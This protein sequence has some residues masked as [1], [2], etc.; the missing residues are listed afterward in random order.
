MVWGIGEKGIRGKGNW[1]TGNWGMRG[2]REGGNWGLGK[3]EN[4]N[5][6]MLYIIILS[7]NSGEFPRKRGKRKKERYKCQEL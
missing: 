3:G 1:G 7:R 2:M 4:N 6:I 5:I